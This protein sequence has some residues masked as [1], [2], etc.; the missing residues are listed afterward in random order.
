MKL[1][2]GVSRKIGQANY[3]SEGASCSLEIELDQSTLDQPAALADRIRGAYQIVQQAVE[4]QLERASEPPVHEI[5]ETLA[6][7]DRGYR[8]PQEQYRQPPDRRPPDRRPPQPRDRPGYRQGGPADDPPTTGRQF[9]GWIAK[10][11]ADTHQRVRDLIRAWGLPSRYLDWG[12]ADVQAV[13]HELTGVP[14]SGRS[15][16][17]AG[18]ARNNGYPRNGR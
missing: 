15:W 6:P 11:D 17:A 4:D 7:G 16:P 14:D 9:A 8:P 18:P 2:V 13:Y 3:G 1:T 5:D 10:Q 12:G